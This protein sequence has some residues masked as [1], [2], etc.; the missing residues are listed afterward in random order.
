MKK[1][2]GKGKVQR[3]KKKVAKTGKE[4]EKEKK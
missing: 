2:L 3:A 4:K 1:N